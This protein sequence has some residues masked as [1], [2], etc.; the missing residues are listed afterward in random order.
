[1]RC[2]IFKYL[3]GL[4]TGVFCAV[5]VT[6]AAVAPPKVFIEDLTTTELHDRVNNG[7]TTILIPIGG[8]EQNGPHMVLG[9]H[10]VRARFL[11]GR[12][13][14]RLGNAIVA[15][16]L[17]YVPEGSITPP[18]AHMRFSGTI[19]ISESAFESILE[20]TAK[21]FRQHGFHDIVF[22]SDHG[23]YQK[24]V[25]HA[26]DKINKARGSDTTFRAYDLTAYYEASQTAF[27]QLLRGKGFSAAEIGIHAGLADTSLAMAIDPALVHTDRL[28]DAA[29]NS[30]ANGVAGDPRKSTAEIGQLGVEMIVDKSVLAIQHAVQQRSAR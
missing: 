8:T 5:T 17:A 25:Q 10:N 11:A 28:A 24:S 27:G 13:A 3:V 1:M 2:V 9:K 7:T 18:A 19:S 20:S 16:V 21:S 30:P 6:H 23:G 15:P 14:E 12:I 29:R 26:T 22:L 4:A